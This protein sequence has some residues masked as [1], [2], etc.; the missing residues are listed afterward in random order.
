MYTI[1]PGSSHHQHCMSFSH[2]F[3]FVLLPTNALQTTVKFSFQ[4]EYTKATS[5]D[6]NYAHL[7]F[8]GTLCFLFKT[9]FSV[10][11]KFSPDTDTH[12][13]C[14]KQPHE[15]VIIGNRE[16]QTKSQFLNRLLHMKSNLLLKIKLFFVAISFSI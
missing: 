3:S 6:N 12:G 10:I 13:Y 8:Q 11:G 5:I 7:L 9:N 15:S 2:H 1:V 16:R 14:I 4:S